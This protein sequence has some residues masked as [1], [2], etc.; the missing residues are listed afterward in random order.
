MDFGASH[1]VTSDLQNMSLHSE[2][3]GSDDIVIGNGTSLHITHIG[4]TTL[5]SPYSNFSQPFTLS[6]VLCVPSMKKNL[7]SISKFC[8]SNHIL[9]EFLPFFFCGERSSNGAPLVIGR[10]RDGVYE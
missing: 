2:Y 9:V 3:D 8:Q 4:F 7:V 6:N 10:N 1:R 5:F